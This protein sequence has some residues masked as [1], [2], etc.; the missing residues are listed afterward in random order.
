MMKY[1]SLS[2]TCGVP[3]E[4][5]CPHCRR[6]FNTEHALIDHFSRVGTTFDDCNQHVSDRAKENGEKAMKVALKSDL[7]HV[8]MF[9][10]DTYDRH[11]YR[12]YRRCSMPDGLSGWECNLAIK[13][14]DSGRILGELYYFDEAFLIETFRLVKDVPVGSQEKSQAERIDELSNQCGHL[15]HENKQHLANLATM[16]DALADVLAWLGPTKVREFEKWRAKT[17]K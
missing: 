13:P 16:A 1:P 6:T 5:T 14:I 11:T 4:R 7:L 2:E 17:R 9:V 12:L 3:I 8:G 15:D 10:E